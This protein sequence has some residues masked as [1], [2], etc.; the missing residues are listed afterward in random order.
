MG[1][2]TWY[3]LSLSEQIVNKI[4]GLNSVYWTGVGSGAGGSTQDAK[5]MAIMLSK[6]KKY[7]FISVF[8]WFAN[9]IKINNDEQEGY[10]SCH[11]SARYAV[12]RDSI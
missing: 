1:C 12:K 9:V 8:V 10:S 5:Q 7:C 2:T 3:E 6:R 11:G 4:G